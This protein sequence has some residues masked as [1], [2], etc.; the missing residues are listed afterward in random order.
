M[1][2]DNHQKQ[3]RDIRMELSHEQINERIK[4]TSR[5]ILE[6]LVNGD[7]S[8]NEVM[9][10]LSLSIIAMAKSL[11]VEKEEFFEVT[12]DHWDAIIDP[13]EITEH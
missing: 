4:D 8:P 10:T 1:D 3:R 12:S 2:L 13:D 6:N 11:G 5:L 7:K 9:A